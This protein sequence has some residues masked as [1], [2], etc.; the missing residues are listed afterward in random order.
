MAP[1]VAPA[2][3][4]PRYVIVRAVEGGGG[5]YAAPAAV[6]APSYAAPAPVEV[7]QPSYVAPAPV[8]LP[9]APV[10][11]YATAG[12][13]RAAASK[14][15]NAEGKCSNKELRKVL[16]QEIVPGDANESKRA[17]YRV[18]N[19]QFKAANSDKGIDVICAPSLISYRVATDFYC[20]YTKEDITCFAFQQA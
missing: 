9:A 3:C 4:A 14:T 2:P 18:A 13:A 12:A 1:A 11:S 16:E 7:A 5:G 6:A 10:A 19:E 17:V 20:E 8:A 15:V